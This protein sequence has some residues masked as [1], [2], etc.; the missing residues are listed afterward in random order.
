METTMISVDA[1]NPASMVDP[2]PAVMTRSGMM[3]PVGLYLYRPLCQDWK[4]KLVFYGK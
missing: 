3:M 4:P 1:E 2:G